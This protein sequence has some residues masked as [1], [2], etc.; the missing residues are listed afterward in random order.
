MTAVSYAGAHDTGDSHGKH[1]A[2]KRNHQISDTHDNCIYPPAKISGHH[3]KYRT[4]YENQ[5]YDGKCCHQ[6]GTR[7]VDHPG[8]DIPSQLICAENVLSARGWAVNASV[9]TASGRADS[10]CDHRRKNSDK[11]DQKG[12]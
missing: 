7:P 2:R 6:T 3:T 1:H 4:Q 10:S 9:S 5:N 11:N 8:K 12:E